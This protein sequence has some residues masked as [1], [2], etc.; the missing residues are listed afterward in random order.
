MSGRGGGRGRGWRA[1]SLALASSFPSRI[2]S[3]QRHHLNFINCFFWRSA[4]LVWHG[5]RGG[6]TKL[7]CLAFFVFQFTQPP[8]LFCEAVVAL[9]IVLGTWSPAICLLRGGGGNH[10]RM[11]QGSGHTDSPCLLE[12]GCL[13]REGG[14]ITGYLPAYLHCLDCIVCNTTENTWICT[15]SRWA[16]GP[17]FSS[18]Q[19]LGIPLPDEGLLQSSGNRTDQDGSR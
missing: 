15:S 10:N 8:P 7:A 5:E 18:N 16:Y 17:K 3:I 1:E 11:E 4:F 14:E 19:P 6:G 9:G 2:A 12:R 13:G